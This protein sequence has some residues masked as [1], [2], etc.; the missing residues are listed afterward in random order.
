MW[1]PGAA[2]IITQLLSHRSLRGMGW[3][4][5]PVRYLLLGYGL[6]VLYCVVVYGF[7]W[8]TGLGRF[9]PQSLASQMA[10]SLH[11]QVKSPYG[12]AIVY[13]LVA[14]T[15]G[16]V[17]SCASA[18]G[19]E[20]GWRGLLVP[21]LSKMFPFT[22]TTL[23]SGVI[24][25]L[26]HYPLVLF[27]GYHNAGAPVWYGIICFTILVLGMSFAFAWLRL[28]SGSLWAAVAL[29]A[30]H[31]LFIQLVFTP[32]TASTGPTPYVIDEFGAGLA[33]AVL[34]VAYVFWRRRGAL[35]A[36]ASVEPSGKA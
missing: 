26:W 32:L 16:F 30:S 9:D 36:V 27:G 2:A 33:I 13:T 18:L 12:F 34:V 14:A 10:G 31:N 19:E 22:A 6:P 25:A 5:R 8:F 23:I 17:V 3:S 20:I 28:K 35:P 7:T 21:E 4:L 11:I 24:W 1:S 15:L 29:H